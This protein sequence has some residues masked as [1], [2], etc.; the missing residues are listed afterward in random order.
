MSAPVRVHEAYS[1]DSKR[2]QTIWYDDF[3]GTILRDE[4]TST[5]DAGGSIAVVD[6]QTGGIAR[7][8]THTDDNDAYRLEW[9][10]IRSLLV[11]KQA[12][13]EARLTLASVT[14][15]NVALA[16]FNNATHLI[17]MD[18]DTDVG[19]EVNWQINSDDGTGPT[20][21]DG[22]IAYSI[23]AVILRMEAHTHGANHAHFYINDVEAANS[24][25]STTVPSQYLMPYV[26]VRTR[27]GAAA[28]TLDLD[29]IVGRQDR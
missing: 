9:N 18:F 29:Y 19:G 4:W 12:S 16:L 7:I 24:P 28:K 2:Q 6:G 22:G 13:L 25:L 15:I 20:G 17:S 8:T 11:S 1:F 27:V 26:Y 14:S 21:A 5:G 23:G 3:L 10:S